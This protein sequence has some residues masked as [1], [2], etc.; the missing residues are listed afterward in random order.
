M[1]GVWIVHV[2][3]LYKKPP[4]GLLVLLKAAAAVS[5]SVLHIEV[6]ICSRKNGII[7]NSHLPL[8]NMLCQTITLPLA[9][10]NEKSI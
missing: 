10:S 3:V 8:R 7:M 9:L 1:F 4:G 6:L 5:I 2:V